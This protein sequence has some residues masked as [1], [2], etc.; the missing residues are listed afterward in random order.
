[1]RSWLTEYRICSAHIIHSRAKLYGDY[2]WYSLGPER[3]AKSYSL[4]ICDGTRATAQGVIGTISR[5]AGRLERDFVILAR[6][7][8]SPADLK[9]LAAWAKKRDAACVMVDKKEG[10]IKIASKIEALPPLPES[11][12][13]AEALRAAR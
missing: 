8:T 3:L 13:G 1:M 7:V 11:S 6:N 9:L 4:L 12:S 2:V 5:L 10:F